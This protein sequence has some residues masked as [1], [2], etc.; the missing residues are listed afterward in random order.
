MGKG[1]ITLFLLLLAAASHA[2][3]VEDLAK[4][5]GE[6]VFYSSLNNEQIVTFRD[7]FQKKYPFLKLEFYR[8]TSE[9]LWTYPRA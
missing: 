1:F 5:E 7:A 8:G 3:S 6:V 2:A 4:K 9:Y